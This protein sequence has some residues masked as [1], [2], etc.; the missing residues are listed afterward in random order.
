MQGFFVEHACAIHLPQSHE[1]TQR[2][3]SLSVLVSLW[4][5]LCCFNEIVFLDFVN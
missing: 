3:D 2:V 1:E 5:E 4:P